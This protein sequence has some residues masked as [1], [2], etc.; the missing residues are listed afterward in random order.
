MTAI[1]DQKINMHYSTIL[2]RADLRGRQAKKVLNEFPND[3]QVWMKPEG[4]KQ[5]IVDED[6]IKIAEGVAK[7]ASHEVSHKI[8]KYGDIWIDEKHEHDVEMVSLIRNQ[9]KEIID[10]DLFLY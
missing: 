3:E 9:I 10:E 2:Y 8:N 6:F 4:E 7:G 1:E 5:Q